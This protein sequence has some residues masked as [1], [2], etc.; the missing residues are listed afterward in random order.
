MRYV[1][2][3]KVREKLF[4]DSKVVARICRDFGLRLPSSPRD[5]ADSLVK[6]FGQVQAVES[7]P[8]TPEGRIFRAAVF[9]LG[10]N[11]R[12]WATFLKFEERNRDTLLRSYDPRAFANAA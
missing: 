3:D 9:A 1:N 5:L 8:S 12:R 11:S 4:A 7:V 2:L 6:T 10:S